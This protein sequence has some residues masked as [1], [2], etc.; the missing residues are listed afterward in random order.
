MNG[1]SCRLQAHTLISP[2]QP[3]QSY[4][5][6]I[7]LSPA[8]RPPPAR[9]RRPPISGRGSPLC[10]GRARGRRMHTLATHDMVFAA[11]AGAATRES[12]SP[13]NW[14]RSCL[15]P[16]CSAAPCTAPCPCRT[17]RP[18]RKCQRWKL[19][20]FSSLRQTETPTRCSSPFRAGLRGRGRV[21]G[22]ARVS[23]TQ[24][25]GTRRRRHSDGWSAASR[26]R[27]YSSGVLTFVQ[28]TR[29]AGGGVGLWT[30]G[31]PAS[32]LG[33]RMPRRASPA[34]SSSASGS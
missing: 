5:N 21:H 22:Y 20:T 23:E 31:A 33:A 25:A 24:A 11:S 7:S 28:Q 2:T 32:A 16:L 12:V 4:P 13:Q 1:S 10:F 29:S 26:V 27:S 9:A 17:L 30:S 19:P 14:S 8:G 15:R 6:S 18:A 34:S 3:A